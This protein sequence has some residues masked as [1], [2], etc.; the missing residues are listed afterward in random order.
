MEAVVKPNIMYCIAISSGVEEN[1]FH[2]CVVTQG[3]VRVLYSTGL[4]RALQ[5][6]KASSH[7]KKSGRSRE[8]PCR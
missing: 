6:M 2:V 1:W 8:M 4:I 7:G 5:S 3:F